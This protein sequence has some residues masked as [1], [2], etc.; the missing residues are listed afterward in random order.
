MALACVESVLAYRPRDA[1]RQT[2]AANESRELTDADIGTFEMIF[3][4]SPT[5]VGAGAVRADCAVHP[6]FPPDRPGSS[7]PKL[8]LGLKIHPQAGRG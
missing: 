4:F 5:P 7:L 1:D 6:T 8:Q 3:D 2:A